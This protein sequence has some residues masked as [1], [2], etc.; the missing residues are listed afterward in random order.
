M[1]N[2]ILILTSVMLSLTVITFYSCQKERLQVPIGSDTNSI[3]HDRDGSVFESVE[4]G[5][6]AFVRALSKAL[7]TN[8]DFR[9]YIKLKSDNDGI[10]YAELLPLELISDNVSDGQTFEDVISEHL[11]F[12]DGTPAPPN[13][14]Q[15][16][17]ADDPLLTF[18][19][20]DKFI[21][22]DWDTQII[23][24][25]KLYDNQE[26]AKFYL[27]GGEVEEDGSFDLDDY[28]YIITKTSE[29]HQIINLST[30]T[31]LNGAPISNFLPLKFWNHPSVV[32]V[33]NNLPTLQTIPGHKL[34]NIKKHVYNVFTGSNP[35]GPDQAAGMGCCNEEVECFRDCKELNSNYWNSFKLNNVAVYNSLTACDEE[36]MEFYLDYAYVS[37]F[38]T[39]VLDETLP[40]FMH[41]NQL[42]TPAQRTVTPIIQ[43]YTI[44]I[45]GT[46]VT[47][48]RLVGFT[49]TTTP[50]Q[51][52][53]Y[54]FWHPVFEPI[55]YVMWDYENTGDLFEFEA[56]EV[57]AAT[58]SCS[59]SQSQT[60]SVNL[61][62]TAQYTP[63]GGSG[64][65]G[66]SKSVSR[67]HTLVGTSRINLGDQFPTYCFDP[68]G[69]G[70]GL[71]KLYST[72]AVTVGMWVSV[73]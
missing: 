9:N 19:F 8:E 21:M 10:R 28:L 43:T 60:W 59:T 69:T 29:R 41:I 58:T 23:P 45:F 40:I 2:R 5:R 36:D 57:D 15:S 16:I 32:S 4:L 68:Y 6:K 17:I 39:N 22:I 37:G 49:V 54:K 34:V 38:G 47:F 63:V 71:Q 14:L 26:V 62:F 13:A 46:K 70:C 50:I 66:W 18:K 20:P 44:K 12:D 42:V 56:S 67:V 33:L 55:P 65:V 51:L 31:S 73:Y 52:K 48:V 11:A 72:N 24:F 30:N 64:G 27:G 1:K 61:N 7:D 3:V 25:V 53:T 35:G